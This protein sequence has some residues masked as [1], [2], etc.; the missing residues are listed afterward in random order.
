MYILL[1]Y[2][3]YADLRLEMKLYE[4]LAGVG[5]PPLARAMLK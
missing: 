1:Q 2:V 3:C 5:F 4:F